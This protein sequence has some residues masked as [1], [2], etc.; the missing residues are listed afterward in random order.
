[1]T[2]NCADKVALFSL[3]L[4]AT[5]VSDI[6]LMR[7][8]VKAHFYAVSLIIR[9]SKGCSSSLIANKASEPYL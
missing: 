3:L 9:A 8:P 1:M 2:H 6:V 7:W 5:N 4:L